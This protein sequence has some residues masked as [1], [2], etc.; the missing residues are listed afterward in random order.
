MKKSSYI[1]DAEANWPE[2]EAALTF[3]AHET[4]IANGDYTPSELAQSLAKDR[5]H[6]ERVFTGFDDSSSLI[7]RYNAA[8]DARLLPLFNR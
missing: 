6:M 7:A 4:R 8:L 5:A 3:Q 2:D 1:A